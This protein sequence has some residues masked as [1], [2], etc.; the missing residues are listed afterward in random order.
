MFHQVDKTKI[1]SLA[2]STFRP[3]PGIVT[4]LLS[5]QTS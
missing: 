5:K 2:T 4:D 1:A 3:F